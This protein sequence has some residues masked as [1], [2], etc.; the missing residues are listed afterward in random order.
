ML[1]DLQNPAT[2]RFVEKYMRTMDGVDAE[3][4]MRLFHG[5][6]DFTADTFGG[7]QTVTILQGG[8]GLHAQRLIVEKHYDMDRAKELALRVA[9]VNPPEEPR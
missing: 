3:Y 2:A 7:W 9:A 1:G 4:R 5:I 6:R 8:G